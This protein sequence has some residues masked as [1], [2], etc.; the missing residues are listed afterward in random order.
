MP[1]IVNG[2]IEFSADEAIAGS[3]PVCQSCEIEYGFSDIIDTGIVYP[4]TCR[5]CGSVGS[6]Y[7]KTVFDGYEISYVPE[8]YIIPN[9]VSMKK[10]AVIE[11]GYLRDM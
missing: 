2:N 3:C 5:S 1:K 7:D 11:N 6:Q 9:L 8:S 10:I 4:F